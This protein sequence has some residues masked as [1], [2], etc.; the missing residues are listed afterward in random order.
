MSTPRH[1]P[2]ASSTGVEGV[3]PSPEVLEAVTSRVLAGLP[4]YF[5]ELALD[6]AHAS[7]VTSRLGESSSYPLYVTSVQEGTPRRASV[8]VV[9][10]FAPV[11]GRHSEGR[12]EYEHL[13][14]MHERLRGKGALRVPRPLDFLD[15]FQALVMERVAGER[16]S[17]LLLRC[18]RRL[19]PAACAARLR[20]AAGMCGRWLREYHDATAR[21]PAAPFGG[22]YLAA[23][24]HGLGTLA[25]SGFP[26]DARETTLA[27]ARRLHEYGR[28]RRVPVAVRH[29]DFGPQNVHVGDDY[30]C[31]FDLSHHLAAPVYDDIVYF[32]VTLETMNPYP[33]ELRF[34]RR[35]VLALR[36]PFLE[37]YFGRAT[38]DA[39]TTLMLEGY[40][41]KAL[42]ARCLKQR[43]NT[44]AR[45]RAAGALFDAI[46]VRRRYATRLRAQAARV[47]A[48]L[49]ES[50]GAG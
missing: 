8:S 43:R 45:G 29:G 15:E 3:K 10:K 16:F 40:Y 34:D 37:G 2:E 25:A 32:L 48:V 46:W 22:E 38:T 17:R 39:E 20:D 12:T 28:D 36:G 42:V 9:V 11:F 35:R 13:L 31:V 44:S 41:L 47:A 6:P 5:P 21:E 1:P 19:A 7:A 24:E 50:G 14:L 4:R 30:V 18:A 33:R 26:R 49:P 27:L 23:L